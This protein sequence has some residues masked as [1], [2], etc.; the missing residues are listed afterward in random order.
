[1][2]TF[3]AAQKSTKR[4]EINWR[5]HPASFLPMFV[6]VLLLGAVVVMTGLQGDIPALFRDPASLVV[7][8]NDAITPH[9][10]IGFFSQLGSAMWLIAMT[11]AG[12]CAFVGWRF[13]LLGRSAV[14]LLAL[15][16]VFGLLLGIDDLFM[17]HEYAPWGE[18]RTYLVYMAVVG[19]TVLA[20]W[21]DLLRLSWVYLVLALG[22]FALS[23]GVD[24][25][26]DTIEA[27]SSA[28]TRMFLE[29]GFKLLGIAAFATHSVSLSL[30]LLEQAS[31]AAIQ[32]QRSVA[33][34]RGI[35]LSKTSGH[36]S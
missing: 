3:A 21:R 6:M 8:G 26:T 7:K 14:R 13:G 27:L 25:G 18:K 22:L 19:V 1:M 35:G 30:A 17:V 36:S 33:T 5:V 16:A 31:A 15:T 20:Y 11:F 24:L 9:F 29:D 12:G 4:I 2:S 32:P 10:L 23:V 28:N 34:G